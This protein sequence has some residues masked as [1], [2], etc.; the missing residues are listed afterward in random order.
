MIIRIIEKCE[1]ENEEGPNTT[2]LRIVDYECKGNTLFEAI[3]DY[4]KNYNTDNILSS[5]DYFEGACL[6]SYEISYTDVTE[7]YPDNM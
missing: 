6:D 1:V 7:K 5:K 4:K 2:G 3:G